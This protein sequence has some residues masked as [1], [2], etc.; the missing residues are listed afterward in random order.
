MPLDNGGDFQVEPRQLEDSGW[1]RAIGGYV[2]AP[3][4]AT[5]AV[6]PRH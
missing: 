2:V 3:K 6:A 5:V 4:H 1:V